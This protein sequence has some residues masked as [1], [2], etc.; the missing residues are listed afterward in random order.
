VEM[1]SPF[2]RRTRTILVCVMIIKDENQQHGLLVVFD[3]AFVGTDRIRRKLL[4][5]PFQLRGHSS[6]MAQL[7]GSSRGLQTWTPTIMVG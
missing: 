4:R 5:A 1:R 2:M 3:T 7:V 6:P